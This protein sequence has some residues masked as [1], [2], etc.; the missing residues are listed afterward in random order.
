M[1][2]RKPNPKSPTPDPA[3]ERH[4]A[5][6]RFVPVDDLFFYARSFHEAA[7]ALAGS[8]QLD[9]N[10]VSDVDFSP[11]VFLYR[12]AL[13]L[14]LKALVLGGGCGFLPTKPDP[15]SVHKTHSVSWLAQFVCQIV[16]ALKWEPE[17]KCQG[18]ENLADFKAVV[19]SVNSV[20]PGSYSFHLPVATEG[21]GS[22]NVRGF[23]ARMDA[24]LALLDSTADGLAAEW[25][26]RNE[27]ADAFD[28]AFSTDG[29]VQ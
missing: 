3:L 15:L 26:S 1:Q 14:H 20:D 25:D 7:K 28:D 8:L 21:Q 4:V 17:F 5:R 6:S 29:P 10:S 12:H 19:E 16:T 13:E 23:A 24:L 11:V 18:V 22:F 27:G 2:W 9:G